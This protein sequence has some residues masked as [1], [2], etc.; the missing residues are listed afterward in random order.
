MK[1]SNYLGIW[2]SQ[3]SVTIQIRKKIGYSLLDSEFLNKMFHSSCALIF[4][5]SGNNEDKISRKAE[6]VTSLSTD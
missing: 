5:I 3:F 2:T 6:F 4:R 1:I